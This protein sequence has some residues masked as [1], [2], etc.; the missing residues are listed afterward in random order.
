MPFH[1]RAEITKMSMFHLA[2]VMHVFEMHGHL[3]KCFVIG[4]EEEQGKYAESLGFE[5]VKF[6]NDPLVGKMRKMYDHAVS[7]DCDY[8][9]KMDSNNLY[10]VDYI[11]D[12]AR[13]LGENFPPPMF[14]TQ[15][16]LISS[17]DKDKTI[18]F[19]P[20]GSK[21]HICGTSAFIKTKVL[22]EDLNIRDVF[23]DDL[24]SKFDGH[25]NVAVRVKYGD[26]IIG[27]LR[28]NNWNAL[29]VKESDDMHD[30]DIYSKFAEQ[31]ELDYGPS[32]KVLYEMFEE[33]EMLDSGYFKEQ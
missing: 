4:D 32:K 25:L 30:Y 31:N 3:T 16:F 13:F 9:C 2:R 14:G 5:W 17:R 19:S 29:D 28:Y 12:C 18:V 21:Q 7:K 27:K 22:K 33:L 6:P 20:M 10:D 1:G 15:K 23:E 24:K 11:L 8:I 26:S